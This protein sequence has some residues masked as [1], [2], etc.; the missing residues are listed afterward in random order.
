MRPI[1]YTILLGLSIL[2]PPQVR[3]QKINKDYVLRIDKTHEQVVLDGL[4]NESV[5]ETADVADHF[6]MILPQ[7]DT[8]ATQ[9]SE[10]RMTYDQKNIYIAVIFFNNNVKGDYVVESYKRDFSF[11]K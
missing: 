10:V 2:Y 11:G 8:A 6:A 1:L 5:W 9:F 7:D 4:L 3:G